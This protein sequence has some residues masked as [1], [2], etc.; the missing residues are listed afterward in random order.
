M[1][2]VGAAPGE[3]AAWSRY[4]DADSGACYWYNALTG[5]TVWEE[6]ET[7]VKDPGAYFNGEADDCATAIRDEKR[8]TVRGKGEWQ[9]TREG[10]A[11]DEQEKRAVGNEGK[12]EAAPG[13]EASIVGAEAKEGQYGEREGCGTTGADVDWPWAQAWDEASASYY[14][15]HSVSGESS[16][17]IPV[18]RKGEETHGQEER[19]EKLAAAAMEPANLGAMVDEVMPSE[20]RGQDAPG[21]GSRSGTARSL[22][23][24]RSGESTGE[25][26][27][28]R[29]QMLGQRRVS[30]ASMDV[31]LHLDL[32][33]VVARD[34]SEGKAPAKLDEVGNHLEGTASEDK[35]E[36]SGT[37][38]ASS[39]DSSAGASATVATEREE[40]PRP[41]T[42]GEVSRAS[43]V[44]WKNAKAYF[45]R[46]DIYVADNPE[47]YRLL[48]G[49]DPPGK[50]WTHVCSLFAH[51][52]P[53]E[54]AVRHTVKDAADLL[55][56]MVV[57]Q[58]CKENEAHESDDWNAKFDFYAFYTKIA[59]TVRFDIQSIQ[60]PTCYKVTMGKPIGYWIKVADFY[61][62]RATRFN[63]LESAK[64]QT[65]VTW[66]RAIADCDEPG[67]NHAFSFF[68][69]DD[70]FPGVAQFYVQS[71]QEKKAFKITKSDPML[72]WKREA[73]FYAFEVPVRG[74][75]RIFV[76]VA[77]EPLRCKVALDRARKPYRDLFSFYAYT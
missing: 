55:R 5:D 23:P 41:A 13:W 36:A 77:W 69:F 32:S 15:Y 16:W 62:Y 29:E 66:S 35:A 33:D 53:H 24:G 75:T 71:R 3:S 48:R 72:D 1:N 59:G 37:A 31:R 39:S 4:F 26:G 64:G 11:E 50:N 43:E 19:G 57:T 25:R 22:R 45:R 34:G 10:P 49:G 56:S 44:L 63:V 65:K 28:E 58:Y 20:M 2:A 54:T 17:D 14:W 74:T 68:A 38:S 30:S 70:C 18:S 8:I 40:T 7:S 51:R 12:E 52:N 27:D 67:W 76:Q 42:E 73:D 9:E 46:I 60:N 6:D 47:R 21:Q 61:A